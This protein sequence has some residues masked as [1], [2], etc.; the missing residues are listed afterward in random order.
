MKQKTLGTTGLGVSEICLGTMQFGWY[1]DEPA[2]FAMM[3]YYVERGGNFLD[4][5]DMYSNWAPNNPGGVS[6]RIIG[7]W[8]KSRGCRGRIVL[9]TKCRGRMWDGADG[10]GLSRSH[11]LRA[12]EDS[13]KRLQIDHIDLYQAHWDDDV[14]PQDETMEAVDRLVKDGKVRHLGCSNFSAGRLKSA[15]EISNR[16]R[17]A[18]YETV[19]PQYNLAFRKEYEDAVMGVCKDHSISCIPYS[20]LGGGLL[21]GKYHAAKKP[22]T[23]RADYVKRYT[24]EKAD[25]IIL[26]LIEIARTHS[27][28]PLQLALRWVMAQPTVVSPIIGASSNEQ[29]GVILDSAKLQLGKGLLEELTHLSD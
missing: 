6:E 15:I 2:S 7:R 19:Q 26:R 13:L 10:E 16:N 25:R 12:C 22:E 28:Q 20:P 8:M 9:A 27:V 1:L 21:T 14:V 5:A 3:D 18:A 24:S 4:T 17:W 23:Y 11:I 29:L